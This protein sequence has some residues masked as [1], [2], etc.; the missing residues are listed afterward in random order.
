MQQ[1]SAP[2]R[3][4]VFG[5][6][7]NENLGDEAIIVAVIQNIRRRLPDAVIY[8][9]SVNPADTARRYGVRAYPIRQIGHPNPRADVKPAIEPHVSDSSSGSQ[10]ASAA[11]RSHIAGLKAGLKRVPV[12]GSALRAAMKLLEVP[13]DLVSELRFLRSS[14]RALRGMDLLLVAGSNQFLDNFGGTWGFPYTLLKWSVLAK[15]AGSKLAFMS[16]GAGPIDARLSRILV[17]FALLFADY[18]SFR[19]TA[20][21]SLIECAG[22]KNR[23]PVYPDLA[24]SL[25]I[26]RDLA[27]DSTAASAGRHPV[28]GINPMPMYDRRYWCVTDDSRYYDYVRKLSEFSAVLMRE[29]YPVFF[30]ATQPKDEN[31]INDVLDMIPQDVKEKSSSAEL[32]KQARSVDGLMEVL[33]TADVVVATRFHGTL[34]ALM[35]E[36]PVLGICYYRKT[37]D[38]LKETGQEAYAVDLDSFQP[39]ELLRRFRSLVANRLAEV[40]KIRAKNEDY[41]N[42]LSEQYDRVLHLLLPPFPAHERVLKVT[43]E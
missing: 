35:A 24:H 15:L 25:V 28:V 42:A 7:G 17:R 23:G 39:D 6:Y 30:F 19:D 32:I 37:R 1:R 33:A 4:G 5:H 2:Y 26:Q 38:L 20:S 41:R 8:G 9:F 43:K 12:I 10:R 14:M 3:I 34:M 18:T 11:G 21:K 16:V 27:R 22:F 36:R 31:V 40:E 13:R 29:G